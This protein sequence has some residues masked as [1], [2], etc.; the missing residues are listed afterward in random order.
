[1]KTNAWALLL[2]LTMAGCTKEDPRLGPLKPGDIAL[3]VPDPVFNN[4]RT[5]TPADYRNETV[6]PDEVKKVPSLDFGVQVTVVEDHTTSPYSDMFREGSPDFL[7]IGAKIAQGNRWVLIN[8]Q[9]GPEAGKAL[10]VI[11][12]YLKPLRP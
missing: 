6:G 9:D 4:S 10:R 3:T 12:S 7:K 1:M 5:T 8:P 2:L 11:R